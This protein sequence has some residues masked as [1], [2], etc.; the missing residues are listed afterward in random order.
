[1]SLKGKVAIITGGGTGIG[2]GIAEVLAEKG[3]KL[4]LAQ[5]RLAAVEGAARKLKKADVLALSV[6]IRDRGEVERMVN[7]T[8]ERFGSVDILV[9][10]A[11]LTGM[12]AI[13]PLLECAPEKVDEIVDANL[14]GTF[15]CSQSVAR[16]MVRAGHGGS[17]IHVSSVGAYA[18]QEFASLYCATKAAQV[19]LAQAMA[20]ELA[21]YGIRV[22]CV[23]PGDIFTEASATITEDKKELGASGRYVR[24]T[25]LGRRGT[26]ADIG[27]A[28]AYLASD[29]AGFVTGTTL[30]V[31]G[32]FL[33]Y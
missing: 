26:P 7:A 33:A 29:E 1:M 11:S 31:D 12:S 8:Q 10:N 16:Q 6:D 30:V 23:A 14:K 3:V 24:Q 22:N 5:R 4:A 18:A 21:P 19:A 28:V 32:G 15:Y 2:F 9:N 13:A 25:P 20:L 27:H 17:I